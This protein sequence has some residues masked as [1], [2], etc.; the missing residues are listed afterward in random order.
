MVRYKS[1]HLYTYP[2]GF[3]SQCV[4]NDYSELLPYLKNFMTSFEDVMGSRNDRNFS[5]HEN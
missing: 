1:A 2:T 3:A 5:E 4:I